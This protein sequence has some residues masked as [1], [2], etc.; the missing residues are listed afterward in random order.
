MDKKIIAAAAFLRTCSRSQLRRKLR[1]NPPDWNVEFGESDPV[2]A[3]LVEA[4]KGNKVLQSK[5]TFPL[6]CPTAVKLVNKF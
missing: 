1:S 2:Y 6:Y 3:T 5:R 4:I